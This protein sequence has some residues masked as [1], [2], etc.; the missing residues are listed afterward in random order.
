[1]V[2]IGG[3]R[4]DNAVDLHVPGGV[5]AARALPVRLPAARRRRQVAQRAI[6]AHQGRLR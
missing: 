1:M 6:R 3:V 2:V 5:P 4:A